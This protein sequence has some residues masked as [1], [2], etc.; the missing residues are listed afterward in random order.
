MYLNVFKPIM[1]FLI[2][3]I[4]LILL[5]PFFVIITLALLTTY[6]TNPFFIQ[7]RPGKN[8]RLFNIVK[9]KTMNEN[10]NSDGNLLPDKDRLTAIGRVLRYTSLDEIPQLINVMKGEMSLVGPRPLLPAY[11]DLYTSHQSRRH[12]VRP[13]ITG[14]AQTK[15]RNTLSWERKF[16]MDI[17]YVDNCSFL[18]DMKILLLTF[19]KVIKSEGISS[20]E[21]ATM[22][23][24]TGSIQKS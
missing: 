14:W 10:R 3:A 22:E 23:R 21:Y 4:A 7:R 2:A 12:E 16:E 11:L 9:F 20:G 6:R 19:W 18:L 17:W 13:G 15:G 5:S 1:D 24:F 8:G